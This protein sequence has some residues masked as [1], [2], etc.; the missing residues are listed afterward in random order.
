M[1]TRKQSGGKDMLVSAQSENQKETTLE[2]ARC[3]D[4]EAFY[5]LVKPCERGIYMAA[6]SILGNPADAEDAAQD[7]V[8]KAFKSISFFR[9]EAKFSTWLI[10]ITINEARMRLRKEH[11]HLYE[12]LDEPLHT[13]EGDYMPKDFA[14]WREIPSTALERR[15]IRRALAKAISALPAEYRSVFILR[16]VQKLDIRETAKLLGITEAN[17]KT[18]LLRA[19][20]QM[21]DA[22]APG[23]GG[24]WNLSNP[25]ARS[26]RQ[27]KT[28][29]FV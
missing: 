5:E 7:A 8:L 4:A 28:Q 25:R 23:W 14:D 16:D 1:K 21:R 22:L 3:G 11:R 15:E 17:V 19:R 20:L 29:A 27:S 12:S 6:L 18:R 10:Q 13:N 24:E 2:Q 26:P 9:G